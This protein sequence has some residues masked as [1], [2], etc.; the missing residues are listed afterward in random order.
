MSY[1]IAT[2]Y[3]HTGDVIIDS[4]GLYWKYSSESVPIWM[5]YGTD[6]GRDTRSSD[7]LRE[8]VFQKNTQKLLTKI[9]RFQAVKILVFP[10]LGYT[11][12]TRKVSTQ[13][14]GNVRY[15][16]LRFKTNSTPKCWCGQASDRPILKKKTELE[17]ENN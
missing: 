13:I 10:A 9:S 2:D 12:R 4:K 16:V 6:F 8:I 11:F 15:G 7:S 1:C 17:T 3:R 14:L 5:K